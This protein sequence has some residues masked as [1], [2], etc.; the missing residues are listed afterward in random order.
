VSGVIRNTLE[1]IL[2]VTCAKE[3]KLLLLQFF[4]AIFE[5]TFF[6]DSHPFTKKLDR[7]IFC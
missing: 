6:L 5:K 3:I 4:Y 2:A 7:N 1:R